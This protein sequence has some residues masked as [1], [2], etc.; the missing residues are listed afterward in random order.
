MNRE[1]TRKLK[2]K[3]YSMGQITQISKEQGFNLGYEKGFLQGQREASE[4]M[5]YMIAYTAE[6][7]FDLSN[8]ELKEL[9][10]GLVTNVASYATNHLTLDDYINIKKELNE[11]GICY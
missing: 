4:I 2:K 1:E 9:M 6:Y 10:K 8:E 3:G 5:F 11:R 7:K